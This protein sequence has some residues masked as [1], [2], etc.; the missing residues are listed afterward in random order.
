MG[1]YLTDYDTVGAAGGSEVSSVCVIEKESL[2]RT[3]LRLFVPGKRLG[4]R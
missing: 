4:E 2:P 3:K 1:R